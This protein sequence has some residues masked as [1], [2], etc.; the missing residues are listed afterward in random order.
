MLLHVLKKIPNKFQFEIILAGINSEK[1]GQHF[2]DLIHVHP[3]RPLQ[4]TTGNSF[5]VQIIIYS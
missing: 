1:V 2:Q 3:C 5:N 4:Q